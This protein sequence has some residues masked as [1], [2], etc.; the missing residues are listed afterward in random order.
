MQLSGNPAWGKRFSGVG[1]GLVE[2]VLKA[3]SEEL[4]NKAEKHL[5]SHTRPS[6]QG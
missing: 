5:P 2:D 6:L 4:L 1:T 3:E